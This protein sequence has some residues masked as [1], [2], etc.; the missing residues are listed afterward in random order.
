V[1]SAICLIIR[2]ELFEKVN[3]EAGSDLCL[4]QNRFL[5]TNIPTGS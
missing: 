2:Q 1:L 3:I 5:Q 4:F